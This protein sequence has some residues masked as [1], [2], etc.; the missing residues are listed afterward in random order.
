MLTSLLITALLMGLGGMVH[1]GAMCAAPCAAALPRG[2]PWPALVGRTLGYAALGALAAGAMGL[3]S[4]WSR[5]SMALQPMWVMLL[6]ATA[7]MGIWMVFKG[8][9][10]PVV[11]DHGLRGY[12]RLQ[13]WLEASPWLSRLPA[14]QSLLPLALGMAWAALPCGLLYAAATVAALADSAGGGAL[15][16][17]VFSLPGALALGYLPRRL[18]RWGETAHSLQKTSGSRPLAAVPVLW[19]PDLIRSAA[20]PAPPMGLGR[21]RMSGSPSSSSANPSARRWTWLADPRWAVRLSGGAL[22]LAASWAL[23]QRLHAQW[24]AWCA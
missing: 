14:L 18:S 17:A 6:A 23:A 19:Q 9:M 10:P 15:V 5:W 3:L 13:T 22:C 21:S 12:R 8:A 16:M 4:A 20:D 7:L 11:Q 2:V 24:L 1:C